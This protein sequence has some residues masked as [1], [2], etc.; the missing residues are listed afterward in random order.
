MNEKAEREYITSAYVGEHSASALI[1]IIRSYRRFNTSAH[2]HLPTSLSFYFL[3]FS[4]S[5]FTIGIRV[6]ILF[7]FISVVDVVVVV[8]VA[9]TVRALAL[10]STTSAAA[11]YNDEALLF[12]FFRK[13]RLTY[14]VNCLI[15]TC[16]YSFIRSMLCLCIRYV[17]YECML[18]L[19]RMH[20]RCRY[21]PDNAHLVFIHPMLWRLAIQRIFL[22]ICLHSL[23]I[24][25][26]YY[27]YYQWQFVAVCWCACRVSV[28]FSFVQT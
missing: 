6:T 4:S 7:Y 18:T 25:I 11:E 24:Y 23:F 15:G 5:S 20:C 13:Q 1:S 10:A 14:I 19:D 27:Y 2:F 17:S 3:S 22:F 12:S 16:Y 28:V 9:F 26:Y 8:F 21:N